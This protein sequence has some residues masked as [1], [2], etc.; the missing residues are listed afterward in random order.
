MF[1]SDA[2]MADADSVE[3]ETAGSSCEA[4]PVPVASSTEGF[5]LEQ[6]RDDYLLLAFDQFIKIIVKWCTL[7]QV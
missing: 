4:L 2:G 3:E 5:P 6:S 1:S 7:K